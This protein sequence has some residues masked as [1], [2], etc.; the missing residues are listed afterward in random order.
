MKSV[1]RSLNTALQISVISNTE[2]RKSQVS[3]TCRSKSRNSITIDVTFCS[4]FVYIALK[5]LRDVIFSHTMIRGLKGR[6]CMG[7]RRNSDPPPAASAAGAGQLLVHKWANWDRLLLA[8]CVGLSFPDICGQRTMTNKGAKRN[9][10]HLLQA[11]QAPVC[12]W[13]ISETLQCRKFHGIFTKSTVSRWV[14]WSLTVLWDSASLDFRQF[15]VGGEG[16]K[17]EE[18][19]GIDKKIQSK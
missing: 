17:K 5:G 11:Q 2:L 9:V 16:E 18:R 14:C 13:S 4:V 12:P 15:Q 8:A 10:P 7:L 1:D 3:F 6:G 19:Y